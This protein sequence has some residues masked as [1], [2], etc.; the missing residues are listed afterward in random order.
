MHTQISN[1]PWMCGMPEKMV[2]AI[3]GGEY[4]LAMFGINDAVNPFETKLAEAYPDAEV[5]Y[6]EAIAG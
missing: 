3:V 5:K 4:V 1:N 6:S 2:I